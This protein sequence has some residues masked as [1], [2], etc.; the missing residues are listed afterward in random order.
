MDITSVAGLIL[1]FILFIL[2]IVTQGSI[3]SFWSTSS[4]IIV[5][6]GT[7]CSTAISYPVDKLKGFL[8][9][10][11]KAFTKENFEIN[12][13]IEILSEL[14]LVAKKNGL[15]AL[16]KYTNEVDNEFMKKSILLVVDGTDPKMIEKMLSLDLENMITR[17]QE[18]QGV[19]KTMGKYA[20]AMGMI[21]TLIGLI[22]ML[23]KLND[24]STL[25][26]AMAVALIT[27]FYGSFLANIIFLPLAGKLQ[28]KS[29]Q[30]VIYKMMIIEGILAVQAGESPLMIKEKLKTFVAD[31]ERQ[32][33]K[34]SN[35]EN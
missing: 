25:G 30:E 35:D 2:A 20:P 3:G 7:L 28:Y 14:S 34:D 10:F 26:P 9:I 5:I 6:G 21:G 11:K 17:H 4:L 18:G 29:D 19:L 27:T 22:L 1:A 8:A 15:L 16:E 12:Q 13:T 31:S 23:K 24:P 32:N 33:T